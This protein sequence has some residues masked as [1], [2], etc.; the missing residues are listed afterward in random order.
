MTWI[1]LVML[2]L[3]GGSYLVEKV[4]PLA[5]KERLGVATCWTM[6]AVTMT[7]LGLSTVG[8]LYMSYT[9]YIAPLLGS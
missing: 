4:L 2:G 1:F 6:M 7:F 8:L 3:I 9:K 5:L